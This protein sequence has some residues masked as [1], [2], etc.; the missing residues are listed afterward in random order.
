M[1]TNLKVR[2][3]ATAPQVIRQVLDCLSGALPHGARVIVFGSH[4]AGRAKNDSDIDLFVIEQKIDDRTAETIRLSEL[5]GRRLIPADVVV[6]SSEMFN[7][8]SEIPNTLAWR[9]AKQGIEYA[10]VH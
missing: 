6:M 7:R 1:S 10:L 5:L 4:A 8:Q 9:V 3:H 2:D